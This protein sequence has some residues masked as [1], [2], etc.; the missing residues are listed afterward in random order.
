MDFLMYPGETTKNLVPCTK[1]LVDGEPQ[2][3]YLKKEGINTETFRTFNLNCL[4]TDLFLKTKDHPPLIELDKIPNDKQLMLEMLL[5]EDISLRIREYKNNKGE[6]Y[7]SH[8][9]NNSDYNFLFRPKGDPQKIFTL[10]H[11]FLCE[12]GGKKFISD[13]QHHFIE[14]LSTAGMGNAE[15]ICSYLRNVGDN[16]IVPEKDSVP[17]HN[18][19]NRLLQIGDRYSI[20]LII[21][22]FFISALLG[23]KPLKYCGHEKD[24][25]KAYLLNGLGM[26]YIWTP[27]LIT[28]SYEQLRQIEQFYRKGKYDKA[29]HKIT[30]W[31]AKNESG[32]N[33]CEIAQAYQIAGLCLILHPDKCEVTFSFASGEELSNLR[34]KAGADYLLRAI[35]IGL[36]PK[37]C[38]EAHYQL[39]DYYFKNDNKKARHH[40][41]EAIDLNHAN[42]IIDMATSSLKTDIHSDTSPE[43]EI[44]SKLDYVIE[45][46]HLYSET[47]VRDCLYLR[48]MIHKNNGDAKAAE[49]D[50]I[51]AAKMGQENAKCLISRKARLQ[52]QYQ[53]AYSNDPEAPCCFVNSLSGH[54]LEFVTSLPDGKWSLYTPERSARSGINF[55]SVSDLDEF[56]QACQLKNAGFPS[57]RIVFLFL[58]ENEE[59]NL[60]QCLLLL[61]KLYNIALDADDSH[62]NR[63]IDSI[64][65]FVEAKYETASMLIDANVNDMGDN[66]YFKVHLI[67]EARDSAHELLC[68]APLFLPYLNT[69]RREDEFH[70]I[71]FGCTETNYNIVKE[72]IACSYMGPSHPISITLLGSNADRLEKRLKQECP[73]IEREQKIACIRPEFISCNIEETDFPGLIYGD[74]SVQE[75]NPIAKA[76]SRGNYF[77]VDL[78][79]DYESIRFAMNLRTWLLR[80]RGTFDRAPFIALKC[81]SS[82]NSYL[83]THLTLSGQAEGNTYYS[84]YDLFPFG[85]TKDMYSYQRLIENPILEQTALRIHK[86]YSGDNERKSE[87]QYYSFSYNADSSLMTAI[88]LIYRFFVGDVYFKQKQDYLN[89]GFY[90]GHVLVSK[91]MNHIR[92]TNKNRE[93]AAALEQSRWNGY[94]LSRGWEPAS[95]LDV[96]AYKNQ[97]T[98]S[99]HKHILAK[100]HPFIRE[101]DDLDSSDLKKSLGILKFK[102]DYSK[103][104]QE[105]TRQ[106]IDDTEKV[107]TPDTEKD[108]AY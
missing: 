51:K 97:S 89:F 5:P 48:G 76:L 102:F 73:G 94:M 31:I 18:E 14:L 62:R 10:M 17:A 21:A 84:R 40:L 41:L 7:I 2:I 70:V 50:T 49:A 35:S 101:W 55:N 23:L 74:T 63:L 92:E 9:G 56:I 98:G 80:S 64:D 75:E 93:T 3:W 66:I 8:I 12:S 24:F 95:L 1:M 78:K 82:R 83:A 16:V 4:F 20:S 100:L 72:S 13:V 46:D 26:E 22:N 77:V 28:T 99:S 104:P 60:N 61:D 27:D 53:P 42:A 47:Q 45:N 91:F 69:T 59:T 85:I 25:H 71:L 65:I 52:L 105:T 79:T 106:S 68:N 43:P 15:L 88:G 36:D 87:N 38:A 57:P 30:D 81:D 19:F 54:N 29:Y 90:R 32:A 34:K 11:R 107:L 96:Q 108:K 67:D 86:S 37:E 39:Y 33:I 58:S 44:L 103:H 6:L